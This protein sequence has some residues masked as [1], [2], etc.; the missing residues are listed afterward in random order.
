LVT[1]VCTELLKNHEHVTQRCPYTDRIPYLQ[2]NYETRLRL[3]RKIV[4]NLV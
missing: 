4:D 3:A 1:R 2:A